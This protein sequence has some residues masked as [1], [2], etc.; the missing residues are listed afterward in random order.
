MKKI[1][2]R[3]FTLLISLC[4]ML[5]LA[6]CGGT[7]DSS[8]DS[9]GNKPAPI[10]PP[11]TI[12]DSKPKTSLTRDEVMANMPESLRGTTLTYMYWWNPKEQMEK[13]AIAEFEKV[14]GIKVE[15]I[16]ASY[17]EFTTQ[18]TSRIASDKSPDLVRLLGNS[19]ERTSALQPITN[20]GFDF[21]DTAWDTQVMKDYTFNGNCYG[22]NLK[23]S[24]IMD[25][26][27]IYYNKNAL[28][29]A[30]ME[31]PYTI[32]KNNPDEWT[33]S[34]FWGMCDE[35]LKANNNR[36]GYYGATFEYTEAYVR[37]MGGYGFT[38]D[39]ASGKFVS[40]VTSKATEIGWQRTLDA[41]NKKWLVSSHD[42]TAFDNGKI[43][44]FW[45]GPYSA[46]TADDRQSA[47]KKSNSLGVV[48][49][50]TDSK[51]QTLYEY[52]AFGIAEGAKNPA[53]APYY[54][55]W[56]LD[57]ESYDMSKVW[58]N[59]QAKEVMDY[60]AS[61]DNI[62]YG[63]SYIPSLESTLKSGGSAQVQ[64]VLGSFKNVVD[65]MIKDENNR[66]SYYD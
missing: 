48:P 44:F 27:V 10:L 60:V 43:L 6:A 19:T 31:D 47:L 9:T 4:F 35:F 45:S 3:A 58:Y 20:S 2:F 51:N 40:G 61:S 56:V 18:L 11:T 30:E 17:E 65:A 55:R 63:N 16:V 28:K 36:S 32:W 5:S 50:P 62:W 8:S 59:A 49:L 23:N 42:V 34:K 25:Y 57:Q 14:T 13:D 7:A 26:A 39:S 1:C 53:A 21:N 41:M 33:W 24:A 12:D 54:L 29:N 46:R 52:T 64:S 22:V 15:P 37:A 38:Y 66:I